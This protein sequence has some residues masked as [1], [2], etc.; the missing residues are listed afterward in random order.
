MSEKDTLRNLLDDVEA[1][2]IDRRSFLTRAAA[3]GMSARAMAAVLGAAGVAVPAGVA[4]AARQ[5]EALTAFVQAVNSDPETLD[6]QDT[7]N[8]AAYTV[9][10]EIYSCLIYKDLDLSYKGLLAESWEPSEDNTEIVFNLRQDVTFHDGSPFNAE[11]VKF[12]FERLAEMGAKS[13]N[14]EMALAITPE[15]IDEYTVKLIFDAPNA[16]FFN[17]FT[18]GYGGMLS[19]TAV[20]AGGD[21]Y[22]RSPVGTGPYMLKD[23]SSGSSVTLSAFDDFVAAPG[24]Y[25]NSGRPHIDERHFNVIAET[26]AQTAS[27][28][29]GEIDAVDLTATDLPRFEN[30]E[31]FEIFSAN[32]TTLGYMGMNVTRPF[33]QDVN[34][35]TAIAHA[36]DRDE[37]VNTLYEG[38]LAE[39]V[40]TP[41]PPSIPGYDKSLEDQVPAL[42]LDAANAL[43]NEAGWVTGDDGIREKD[44]ERFTLGLYTTSTPT[45]GQLATLVQSQLAK[46]GV[47][48]DIN[49]LELAALLDFSPTGEHDLFLLSWGW[50][51]PDALYIFLSGDRVGT[52][53]HMHYASDELDALLVEG[54]Q[55]LDQDARMEVYYRAQEVIIRDSPWVALYMPISK[56][57]V[58]ARFT[59]VDVF[60]TGGLL[61]NDAM[62]ASD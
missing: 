61:M 37:I 8:S 59:G 40:S 27:L 29:T 7:A 45:Q 47:E 11:A 10:N 34:V 55:T 31:N 16:A 60:P 26:F 25:E 56:T 21:Q 18:G 50:S 53:N 24:Y 22:G 36:I 5:D 58:N 6:P 38:G 52:S 30:D 14:Y 23:W 35:R 12:S 48:V 9:F 43:L 62:L 46:I 19:P 2:R 42:D 33:L 49:Q 17:A 15:V 13:P 3:L 57:A 4:T 44:G 1:R 39:V 32:R 20:E 51:D 28:E 41:L 54:Q